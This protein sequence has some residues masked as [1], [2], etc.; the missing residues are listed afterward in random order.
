VAARCTSIAHSCRVRK[1][2]HPKGCIVDSL[3]WLCH[4]LI[5]RFESVIF[6]SHG[7]NINVTSRLPFRWDNTSCIYYPWQFDLMFILSP[8][9]VILFFVGYVSVLGCVCLR[10]FLC[11]VSL[12]G[13]HS[14]LDWDKAILCFNHFW[15]AVFWSSSYI[16]LR[17]SLCVLQMFDKML[18]WAFYFGLWGFGCIERCDCLLVCMGENGWDFYMK[19]IRIC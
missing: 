16:N 14:N 3:S 11:N 4:W 8:L 15:R 5:L 2:P 9:Y 1:R 10:L 19:T 12:M 7:D 17:V 6:W 18:E 13:T